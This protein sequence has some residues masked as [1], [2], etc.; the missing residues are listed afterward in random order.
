MRVECNIEDYVYLC[1]DHL[2]MMSDADMSRS[3]SRRKSGC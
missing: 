1:L 2:G 3:P